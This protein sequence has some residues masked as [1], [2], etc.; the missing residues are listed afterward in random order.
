MTPLIL[1]VIAIIVYVL[2][3]FEPT[4]QIGKRII[5]LLI[6]VIRRIIGFFIFI[7]K[8][9]DKWIIPNTAYYAVLGGNLLYLVHLYFLYQKNEEKFNNIFS[10]EF[11]NRLLGSTTFFTEAATFATL[12]GFL[13]FLEQLRAERKKEAKK[14]NQL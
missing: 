4:D 8:W 10:S 1:S 11:I 14:I 12:L 13:G 2:L 5:K 3:A 7:W 6:S 9:I